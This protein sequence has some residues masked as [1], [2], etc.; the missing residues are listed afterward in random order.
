[1]TLT[2][3]K[4]LNGEHCLMI[5]NVLVIMAWLPTTAARMAITRKGHLNFSGKQ[6][7]EKGQIV[8][9][10][11]SSTFSGKKNELHHLLGKKTQIRK[12]ETC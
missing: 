8:E 11:P 10:S 3:G 9:T 4:Q 5:E 7:N 12:M 6:K 1:M 2:L